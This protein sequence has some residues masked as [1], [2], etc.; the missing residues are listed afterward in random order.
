MSKFEEL[1]AALSAVREEYSAYRQQCM[2]FI[3]QL[4]QGLAE[5]LDAPEGSIAFFAVE[6]SFAGRRVDGPA[7][8][9][10]LGDDTYWHFGIVLDLFEEEGLMPYHNV[11]F[12]FRLK[13][14][15]GIYVLHVEDSQQ[16]EIPVDD[17]SRAKAVYDFI[18]Q[19]LKNR[20]RNAFHNFLL[21]GDIS[22]RFGF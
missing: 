9:M 14:V 19:H 3:G 12:R 16:F 8:S 17:P 4:K 13:E 10:H 20:Y 1:C 22:Q 5:Y 6:G 2:A 11:G 7:A 15:A 18:F 21:K